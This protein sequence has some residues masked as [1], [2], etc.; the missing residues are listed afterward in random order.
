[1]HK[2]AQLLALI[3]A[4]VASL[5]TFMGSTLNHSQEMI[6][7]FVISL[8]LFLSF[9]PLKLIE[10]ERKKQNEKKERENQ[11]YYDELMNMSDYYFSKEIDRILDV[12][13]PSK[14]KRLLEI[15]KN[16]VHK[17]SV[18]KTQA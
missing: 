11:A 17:R 1:M 15:Y 10:E 4:V 3:L 8:L 7:F 12:T 9:K 18:K 5:L 6:F 13:E 16:V 14:K 2:I